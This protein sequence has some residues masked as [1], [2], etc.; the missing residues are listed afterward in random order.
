MMNRRMCM[1]IASAVPAVGYIHAAT[2][3]DPQ[4]E[5]GADVSIASGDTVILTRSTPELN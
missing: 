3:V 1:A 4:W 5:A 2:T